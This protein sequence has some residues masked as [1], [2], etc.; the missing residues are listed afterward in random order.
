M[1][2]INEQ[3]IF[4]P[5]ASG[6]TDFWQPLIQQLPDE[7]EKR[8]IAYAGFGQMPVDPTIHNFAQLQSA[9]LQKIDQPSILIAQSMGG[10]FAIAAALQKP[11]LIKGLVLIATSGGVDLQPFHVADWRDAYQK[12]FL[13]YPDWFVTTQTRYD[14]LLQ[15]IQIPVLL[16]WGDQDDISPIA[17]GEYLLEQLPQATLKVIKGGNHQLANGCAT[18][19]AHDILQY[20]QSL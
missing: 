4:L 8:V 16:I 14:D 13:N 2:M 3:L 7:Y 12:E 15:F 20:L 9:V 6:S 17:V 10:I 19:V 5:G 11:E 18:E 1:K